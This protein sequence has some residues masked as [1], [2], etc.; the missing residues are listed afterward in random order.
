MKT[1]SELIKNNPFVLAPMDDVTDLAFRE[2][3]EELGAS[4]STCELTSIDALVRD[5]VKKDRYA[6]GNLNYSSVQLFGSK[7]ELFVQAAKKV[8]DEADS[9][10]VNFGCPSA[11]VTAGDAGSMLLKDP[12]APGAIIKALVNEIDKPITAKIRLGYKTTTYLQVAKEIEKAGANL[13]AVH[14][15]TAEQKY[16]GKANWDAIKEIYQ[17][18]TIPVIGNGDIREVED[19]DKYLGTHCD[20]LM[21]GRAAIGNPHIF[22][23]FMH[24]YKTGKKL[25]VDDRKSLQ[26]HLFKRYL[27]KL[28]H[29]DIPKK[30]QR[31]WHQAMWFFKGIEGAK[32]LRKDIIEVK[33]DIEQVMKL[34]EEF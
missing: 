31:I 17:E 11:R 18:V 6:R 19:I 4:Y 12:K 25:L 10:D 20:A 26:K 5:C 14:G 2:L 23:E 8:G 30:H 29:Y 1:P 3:C 13:I 9:I 34:V 15:R 32:Q 22:K 21:I 7:P 16:S 24:Y 28:K 33:D 27:E